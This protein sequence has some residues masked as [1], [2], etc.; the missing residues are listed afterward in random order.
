MRRERVM[1]QMWLTTPVPVVRL[2]KVDSDFPLESSG[3]RETVP[4]SHLKYDE[5]IMGKHFAPERWS[6]FGN[7]R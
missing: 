3:R 7:V 2:E 1:A 4:S 6:D 5:L